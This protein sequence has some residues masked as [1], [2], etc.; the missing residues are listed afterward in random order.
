MAQRKTWHTSIPF[1]LPLT[2]ICISR[3]ALAVVSVRAWADARN[4]TSAG[5]GVKMRRE[6]ERREEKETAIA[7]R[8]YSL[9]YSLISTFASRDVLAIVAR[10]WTGRS[11]LY[12]LQN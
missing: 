7:R 9:E 5:G 12:A 3:T 6:E 11:G 1:L 2:S 8:F 4:I 10:F